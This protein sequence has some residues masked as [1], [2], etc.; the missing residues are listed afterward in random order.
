MGRST[1][2]WAGIRR[3]VKALPLCSIPHLLRHQAW[4]CGQVVGELTPHGQPPAFQPRPPS[5]VLPNNSVCC[6]P[7]MEQDGTSQSSVRLQVGHHLGQLDPEKA[8]PDPE[9]H[10]WWGQTPVSLVSGQNSGQ[11]RPPQQEGRGQSQG[12]G[13]SSR[14]KPHWAVLAGGPCCWGLPPPGP[15]TSSH[16]HSPSQALPSASCSSGSIPSPSPSPGKHGNR[17]CL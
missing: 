16:N 13:R 4:L 17:N 12:R 7:L 11:N 5:P 9:S 1:Q 6:W 2:V 10:S 14:E 15:Y 3:Y 8:S